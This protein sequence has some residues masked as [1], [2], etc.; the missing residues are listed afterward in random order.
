[1]LSAGEVGLLSGR[2]FLDH[3]DDFAFRV[4]FWDSGV[5]EADSG[6]VTRF[7]GFSKGVGAVP[8]DVV[9]F[10]SGGVLGLLP[11]QVWGDFGVDLGVGGGGPRVWAYGYEFFPSGVNLSGSS[12]RGGLFLR[13]TPMSL[14]GIELSVATAVRGM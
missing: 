14:L 10:S 3:P 13:A 7:H 5:V 12:I 4:G 9:G 1:M 8:C 11:D 2:F 6:S